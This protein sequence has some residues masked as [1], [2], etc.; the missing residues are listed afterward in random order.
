MKAIANP[1]RKNKA[2]ITYDFLGWRSLLQVKAGTCRTL[3]LRTVVRGLGLQR[4]MPIYSY[5]AKDEVG[6]PIMVSYLD[7]QERNFA[8]HSDTK[9]NDQ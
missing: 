1:L 8:K 5:I 9:E 6:R 3:I 4:G 2:E 7:G